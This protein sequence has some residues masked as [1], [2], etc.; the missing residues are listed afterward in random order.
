M[1]KYSKGDILTAIAAEPNATFMEI[2]VT[3]G[4]DYTISELVEDKQEI[5]YKIELNSNKIVTMDKGYL[6]HYFKHIPKKNSDGGG[7]QNYYDLPPNPTQL[8]DL[9][10]HVNMNG[11]L[12]DIFKSCYRAG[13]KDGT[14]DEYDARKRA[15]YSLRELGRLLGRKDYI[16]LAKEVIGHQAEEKG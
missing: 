2:D 14:S 16:T 3:I 1:S 5:H 6:N 15:Y 8:Q 7:G 10:E 4:R 13:R 12:K 9:I 11:N